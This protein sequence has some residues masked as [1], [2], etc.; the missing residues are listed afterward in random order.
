L[1]ADDCCQ[2][3]VVGGEEYFFLENDRGDL[4]RTV[5]GC[6]DGCVYRR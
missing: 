6:K 2:F 4:T 3:K 1:L 5:Y